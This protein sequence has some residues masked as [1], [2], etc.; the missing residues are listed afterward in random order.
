MVSIIYLIFA[1]CMVSPDAVF[2]AVS[3]YSVE[4]EIYNMSVE[5]K[6]EKRRSLCK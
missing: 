4:G 6:E 1:S 3:G 2:N 5:I